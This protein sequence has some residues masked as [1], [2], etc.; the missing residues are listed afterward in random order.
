MSGIVVC[1]AGINGLIA[2]MMLA[3]DGHQVTVLERDAAPPP[4]PSDAWDSWERRGV[5]QFRLP[6]FL[7]PGFR[8]VIEA[9]LPEVAAAL[10]AAGAVR[11]SPLGPFAE[12]MDP[13][14]VNELITARRPIVEAAVAAVAAATPGVT[15]RRGV[16]LAGVVTT[17]D[18]AAG[19]PHVVG[20]R[21][22]DGEEIRGDL[23]VDVLGRRSPMVRWLTEAGC[24]AAEVEEEDSGFVYYG[25]HVRSR[26]GKPLPVGLTFYGSVGLLVLPAEHG[27]AGVGIIAWSGDAELRALRHDAPWR[28]VMALLPP[29]AEVL[30]AEQL[31]DAI[32]VMTGIE[33]RYRR[34]VV[35]GA[36]VATGVLS[37]GDA[38]AATNPTLGRG[39][40]L[41]ARHV[42][43]LRDVLREVGLD[44]H[45][46]LARRFDDVTQEHQTPWYRS[47]VW[48]DRHR[49]ADFRHAIEG[50]EPEPDEL[51]QRFLGFGGAAFGDLTLLP[52]FLATFRLEERPED[53]LADPAIAAHLEANG[54][55]EPPAAEGPTRA[56]VLAAIAN[57]SAPA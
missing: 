19:P 1:G 53:V 51:W 11:L 12:A 20:V 13:E 35:D 8:H 14:G 7:L 57:A 27:V 36:P 48:H 30:E 43:L 24:R 10:E 52:R 39:I 5:G 4:D 45:E 2:A 41:G 25:R 32:A 26:D 50:T 49:I 47:T 33:D 44:D 16:A 56:E 15:I 31:E 55:T 42:R 54:L 37:V 18:A 17:G 40:S 21:T 34:Y 23:V 3:K 29:G 28:A 9:E 46:A 38:W 6:H 22:E